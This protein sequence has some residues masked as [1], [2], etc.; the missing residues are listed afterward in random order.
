MEGR[1]EDWIDR[2]FIIIETTMDKESCDEVPITTESKT[3]SRSFWHEIDA[4]CRYNIM[5]IRFI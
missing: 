5:F 1:V 4:T 3:S 2:H